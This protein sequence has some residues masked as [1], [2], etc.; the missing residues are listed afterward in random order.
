MIFQPEQW[1]DRTLTELIQYIVTKHH[2]YLRAELPVIEMQ[3]ERTEA[4]ESH[5]ESNG[6]KRTFRQFRREMENHMKKEEVVLFPLIEK[7]EQTRTAGEEPPVLP[8]G[9]IEHPIAV[10]KQE[11]D[12]ARKELAEICTLTA[13]FTRGKAS[14]LEKLRTLDADMGVHSR[15][16]DEILF[17]RAIDMER[18]Q[19]Q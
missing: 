4:S 16:E 18:G 12:Q 13:G 9:T 17:P 11:H 8:F 15:L 3:L 2:D 6:L 19:A 1:R 14:T 7:I 10:M 5:T